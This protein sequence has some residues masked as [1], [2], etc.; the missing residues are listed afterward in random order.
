MNPPC[1]AW[2]EH[3][4]F[5]ASCSVNLHVKKLKCILCVIYFLQRGITFNFL[6]IHTLILYFKDQLL[7]DFLVKGI[8]SL[9]MAIR[10]ITSCH[11]KNQ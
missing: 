11:L 4:C 10:A 8:V 3:D 2:P 6:V 7:F 9:V 5:A 1:L